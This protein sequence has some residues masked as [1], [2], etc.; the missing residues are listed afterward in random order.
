MTATSD[1]GWITLPGT[2]GVTLHV[3]AARR[4]PETRITDLY[5]HSADGITPA[6]VRCISIGRLEAEINLASSSGELHASD[7]P[8]LAAIY[9]A[10]KDERAG[11]PEPTLAELRARKP[12]TRAITPR[13][14][15][16]RPIE[17]ETPARFSQRIALAYH[18]HA[19]RTKTVAKA[20][21]EEAGVPVATAN[22]WIGEAR[23]AGYLPN[24]RKGKTSRL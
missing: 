8:T 22:R 3:H 1:D 14:R 7:V 2:D 6:S 17:D 5:I 20:L 18:D 23:R 13:P 12:T 15:L 9:S 19:S 10:A 4:G 21:A 11:T 16:T 24:S